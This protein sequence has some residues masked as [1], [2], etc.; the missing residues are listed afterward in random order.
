MTSKER[1]L[2]SL[3]GEAVDRPAVSFYEIDGYCQDADDPDEFNVFN[4]PSWAP[5]L[6]LARER[7][8]STVA[9][10]DNGTRR[11][12]PDP[13]AERSTWES[14]RGEDGALF[15]RRKVRTDSCV[16]TSLTRRDPGIN[17]VWTVEHLLKDA[18]DLRALLSVP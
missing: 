11:T 5:L 4:D 3:R 9:L 17:T 12:K 16:L 14:W 18:D 1:L 7:S 13:L 15:T 8:D 2:A 10:Y 6:R